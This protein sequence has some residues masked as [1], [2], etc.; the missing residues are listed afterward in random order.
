MPRKRIPPQPVFTPEE[1]ERAK[2]HVKRGIAAAACEREREPARAQPSNEALQTELE[3]SRA[4][5]AATKEWD[6]IAPQQPTWDA[7]PEQFK[8]LFRKRVG[9][10][11]RP[12]GP[13]RATKEKARKEYE[14]YR[15]G[16]TS[17]EIAQQL[18]P[19]ANP[20]TMES[21]IRK[22]RSRFRGHTTR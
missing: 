7:L 20:E 21:Q 12:R 5:D 11:G 3:L 22:R 1:P 14:L 10:A 19:L 6:S 9:H 8:E 4:F 16:E 13:D 2:T 18:Y 15:A 17:K